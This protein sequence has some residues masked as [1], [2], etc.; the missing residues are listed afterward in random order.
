MLVRLMSSKM[1]QII[2][3]TRYFTVCRS[4]ILLEKVVDLRRSLTKLDN[5]F[6]FRSE[7]FR[8]FI[9]QEKF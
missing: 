6:L 9:H 8:V 1:S 3:T 7:M 2:V 4:N 5:F